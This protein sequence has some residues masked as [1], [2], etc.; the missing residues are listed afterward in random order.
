M[1]A[2]ELQTELDQLE[3][4]IHAAFSSRDS[5]LANDLLIE[6]KKLNWKRRDLVE[7]RYHPADVKHE[8]AMMEAG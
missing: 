8:L 5:Q 2:T 6:F 4:R 1:T 3:E 7:A